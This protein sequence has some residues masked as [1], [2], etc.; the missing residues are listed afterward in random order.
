MS[1]TKFSVDYHVRMKHNNNLNNN[2][3]M[4]DDSEGFGLSYKIAQEQAIHVSMVAD[5]SNN[6]LNKC[7]T[8]KCPT[9][10]L[11]HVQSVYCYGTLR[12]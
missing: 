8:I 1:L 2:I 7:V 10:S 3:K 4:N 12:T 9:M 5:P 6:T 11:P